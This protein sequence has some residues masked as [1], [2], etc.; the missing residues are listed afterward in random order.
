M[1]IVIDTSSIFGDLRLTKAKI[2]TL[3]ETARI[4]GDTVYFPQVMI[5][6]AKNIYH[7]NLLSIKSKIEKDLSDFDFILN[8]QPFI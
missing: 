1:F 6:E 2:R 8:S 7:E 3:C 4:T 5:D